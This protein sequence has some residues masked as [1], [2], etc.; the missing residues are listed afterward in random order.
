M[1]IFLR[2]NLFSP[3][4]LFFSSW[5]NIFIFPANSGNKQQICFSSSVK[6]S[7]KKTNAGKQNTLFE[8]NISSGK[9][10]IPEN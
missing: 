6:P 7:E 10:K 5:L 3:E 1:K 2:Q 9:K 8:K 4:K